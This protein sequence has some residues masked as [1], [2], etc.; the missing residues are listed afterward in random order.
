V[1]AKKQNKN[2]AVIGVLSVW[3]QNQQTKKKSIEGTFPAGIM[4]RE[5]MCASARV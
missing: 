3:I 5:T 4:F 2:P 1:A